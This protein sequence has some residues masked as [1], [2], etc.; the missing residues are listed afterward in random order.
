MWIMAPLGSWSN[1]PRTNKSGP[2]SWPILYYFTGPNAL[3][4]DPFGGSGTTL[5]VCRHLGRRCLIYDLRPIRADIAKHDISLG[6]PKE[7]QGC[8]LIVLD[9]PYWRQ[10]RSKYPKEEG[11]FSAVSLDEFNRK[12]EKLIHDCYDTVK[13]GGY[14]AFLIQNTTEL[15]GEITST[16]RHYV[17]HVFDAYESFI[18]AGFTPV[19]RISCPLTW[20]QFAGFDVKE[21]R[22]NKRLLGLVRD[23]LIMKKE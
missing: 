13:A 6:F 17:D 1:S 15:K 18:K 20:E 14:A 16:G 7:A 5:D 19:Q 10:K 11:S 2:T 12:M 22:A 21:A 8:D 9:P 4:V 3:A 23:L